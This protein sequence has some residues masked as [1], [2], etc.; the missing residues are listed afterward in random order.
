MEASILPIGG[1][2]H[3]PVQV[4]F[5]N[6]DKP[7]NRP[8]RFEAF[9]TEHPSFME[10][11]QNW[12]NQTTIRSDNIMYIIQQKLKIIKTNLKQWNKD[13]FGNIFQA[14]RELEEK[15]A[16]LQQTLITE[17]PTEE[18]NTQESTMQRQWEE[19]LKQEETLRRQ[20]SRVQWLKQGERNTSFFHKSTIQNRAFNRILSLKTADGD[21]VFSRDHIG[22]ELNS[23]FTSLLR[24]PLQDRSQAIQKIL[25]AIPSLVTEDQNALLLREFTEQEIEETVFSMATNKAPGPDGFTIEFFKA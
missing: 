17:G 11:I 10:N 22:S 18:R 13:T 23:Y 14:K 21:Q 12:W 3:W 4:H 5:T 9:W 15:M 6:L 8:F 20:K 24:E 19:R 7:Q 25:G 1:S 2:D 16:N